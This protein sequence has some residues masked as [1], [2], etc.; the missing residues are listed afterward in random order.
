MTAEKGRFAAT[1]ISRRFDLR[2]YRCGCSP[3]EARTSL[4]F[5]NGKKVAFLEKCRHWAQP[6]FHFYGNAVLRPQPST[7]L[8]A[9]A[10]A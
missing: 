8:F 1:P 9:G 4:A 2:Q 10:T 6:E 7:N 3:R 5:V